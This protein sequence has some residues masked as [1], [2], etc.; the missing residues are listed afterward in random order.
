MQQMIILANIAGDLQ[1]IASKTALNFG[2]NW[3]HF[4]AQVISFIL[5]AL[6]LQRFA[7]RPILEVLA[8]RKRKVAESLANVEK[9]KSELAKTEAMRQQILDQAQLQAGQL[10]ADARASA[11]YIQETETQKAIA[12]AEQII[13]KAREATTLDRASM[14]TELKREVG[15]LVV[16]TTAKVTGKVLTDDDRRRL[17]DETFRELSA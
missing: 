7:F 2:L 10:I 13:A 11:A 5:V 8:E 17:A 1:E 6:V 16:S 3:H 14:M 12:T 9:I 15:R 4:I